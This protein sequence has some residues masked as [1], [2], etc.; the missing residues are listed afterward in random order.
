M[1]TL[2]LSTVLFAVC[3]VSTANP[4]KRFAGFGLSTVG[5][6]IGCVVTG[7]KLFVNGLYTKNLTDGEQGEFEQ[8]E[9]EL[10]SFRDQ[11]KQVL[12]QRRQQLQQHRDQSRQNGSVQT[13]ND[14]DE[15]RTTQ[16]KLPEPPKKPSFCTEKATTQYVFDGCKVQDGKVYIG[17]E[18]A[19]DL[20]QQ[21]EQEL[22]AFDEKM[23]AYQKQLTS[24]IQQQVEEIFGKQF[25]ALF[26][27]SSSSGGS[28]RSRSG[29]VLDS[30]SSPAPA[31]APPSALE[32]PQPPNF[33]TLIV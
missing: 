21:E 24:N 18:Y 26:G 33:C 4:A 27:G 14:A 31:T 29:E 9:T 19:R 22:A 3:A 12:E 6:N 1:K 17:N 5:G 30:S 10:K 20:S 7:N 25:G 23:T 2:I 13:S 8:Y 11:V 28:G 32:A 16:P 15:N